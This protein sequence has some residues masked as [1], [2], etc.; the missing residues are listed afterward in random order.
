MLRID[1]LGQSRKERRKW[2]K[3]KKWKKSKNSCFL[4][5][6]VSKLRAEIEK[7]AIFFSLVYVHLLEQYLSLDN[8]TSHVLCHSHFGETTFLSF[9]KNDVKN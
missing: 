9:T 8:K 3:R 2:G 7:S 1:F 6:S 4:Y 5:P